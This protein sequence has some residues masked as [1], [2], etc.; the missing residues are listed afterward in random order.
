M[1]CLDCGK[2]NLRGNSII[3]GLQL[4]TCFDCGAIHQVI[5]HEWVEGEG[6]TEEEREES[7]GLVPLLVLV[8]RA[9]IKS[10]AAS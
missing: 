6:E 2:E 8:G 7:S 5:G 10:S 1:K 9:K 4:L 3:E